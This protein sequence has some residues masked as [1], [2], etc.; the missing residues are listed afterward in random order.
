VKEEF[1]LIAGACVPGVFFGLSQGTTK[2]LS[3]ILQGVRFYLNI[4]SIIQFNIISSFPVGYITL[5]L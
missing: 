5:F 1:I 2:P 4:K 3:E